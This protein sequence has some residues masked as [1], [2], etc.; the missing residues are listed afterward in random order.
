MLRAKDVM[1]TE[2]ISLRP[3]MT[4]RQAAAL[5]AEAN[6]T[7]APV[8]SRD[9]DIVGVLSQTDFIRHAVEAEYSSYFQAGFYHEIPLMNEDTFLR[10]AQSGNTRVEELMNPFVVTASPEDTVPELARSLRQHGFH[11]LIIAENKKLLGIVSTLDLLK[12]LEELEH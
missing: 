2:V 12:V 6:I 5:L 8:V 9:G 11:R 7:G 4:L 10:D 1:Q 3:E